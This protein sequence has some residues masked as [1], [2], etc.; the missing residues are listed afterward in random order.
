MLKE[1][2]FQQMT[3]EKGEFWKEI[4]EAEE[5]IEEKVRGAVE[6]QEEG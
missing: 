5:F 3:L 6:Q 4:R 2:K 1:K